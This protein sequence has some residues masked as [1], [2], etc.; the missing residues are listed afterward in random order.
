[1][2]SSEFSITDLPHRV[3]PTAYENAIQKMTEWLMQFSE[4]LSVYQIGSVSQPGISDIDLVAVFKDDAVFSA[5]PLEILNTHERQLFIHNLYGCSLKQFQSAQE[6]SQF[7]N[8]KL[9]SGT[10]FSTGQNISD[11]I[12]KQL[13]QEYV[14]KFFINLL[15]Q[16]EY[17]SIRVRSVMLHV[18]GIIPDLEVLNARQEPMYESVKRWMD[19]RTN[20]FDTEK[21][22]NL[23]QTS[24][25]ELYDCTEQFLNK[26]FQ[27]EQFNFGPYDHFN[28]AKNILIKKSTSFSFIRKG[29]IPPSWVIPSGKK[30][31]SFLNRLNKFIICLPSS[32]TDNGLDEYYRFNLQHREYNNKHLPNFYPLTSSL[33]A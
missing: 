5:Q 2:K 29:I 30:R 24:F 11:N 9:L 8:Y 13:A 28:V 1:V 16:N 20:W 3:I 14:C 17:S 6:F 7:L 12:R 15:L 25:S 19:I 27:R 23:L 32:E 26:Y 10:S 21:D 33:K 18:K 22:D 31:F 4:V